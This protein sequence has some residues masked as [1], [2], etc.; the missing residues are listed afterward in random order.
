VIV[1][2]ALGKSERSRICDET[3]SIF[4]SVLARE[5]ANLALKVVATGGLY[6]GG[7]IPRRI[8]SLLRKGRFMEEYARKG[9]FSDLLSDIPVY[10]IMNPKAALIGTACYGLELLKG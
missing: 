5:A 3:L 8:I 10:V 2:S 4:V 9:V 1:G 7:G 6:I